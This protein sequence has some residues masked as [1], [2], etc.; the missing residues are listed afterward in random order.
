MF[1]IPAWFIALLSALTAVLCLYDF[2]Y[3]RDRIAGAF[4][5]GLLFFAILYSYWTTTDI[6]IT[7]RQGW[8]RAGITMLIILI[9]LWRIGEIREKM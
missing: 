4:S 6:D 5:F 2:I 9:M 3:R 8:V 7:I 1:V